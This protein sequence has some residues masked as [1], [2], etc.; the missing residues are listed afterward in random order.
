MRRIV[1]L[2]G[3]GVLVVGVAAAAVSGLRAGTPDSPLP[4]AFARSV[5]RIEARG[6]PGGA[7]QGSGF[8][9]NAGNRVV[10]SLHVVAGC[11]SIGVNYPV[12][13]GQ[14]RTASAMRV[15]KRHD[16]AMLQ[17]TNPPSVPVLPV[18]TAVPGS[19]A[20][21]VAWGYPIKIRG[22]LDTE[23]RRRD[24]V[25]RL[26]DLLNEALRDEI[27]KVG[28]PALD[29]EIIL[30]DRAHLLPGQSGGPLMDSNG[31]VAAIADGGLER[32]ASEINWAIP[33]TRLN[34][35]AASSEAIPTSGV[36]A[37]LFAAEVVE[38][39]SFPEFVVVADPELNAPA[40]SRALGAAITCGSG[41]LVQVKTRT[42]AELQQFTDDPLGLQ[43]IM[44]AAGVLLQPTDEF[45][46][47]QHVPSGATAVLPAG[48]RLSS[49]PLCSGSL[50]Q[51]RIRLLLQVRP[52]STPMA[53]QQESVGYETDLMSALGAGNWQP[54]PAWSM[55]APLNRFDGLV[56]R[57]KA[58][59]QHVPTQFGWVPSKYLFESLTSRGNTFLGVASVRMDMS[60]QKLQLQNA[61]AMNASLPG[62]AELLA[63]LR[64][65]AKAS[66]GVH[67]STFPI[68]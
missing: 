32:G 30:L 65:A 34:E 39:G 57:R 63:E 59:V 27:Q 23:F 28:M 13:G 19:G 11:T 62:C 68:G 25:A 66:I 46:I 38:D 17:V 47:Y 56:A 3:I 31:R 51:G 35:L 24:A 43:Q 58:A 55:L 15:L 36:T 33:A 20:T 16:L 41:E 49:G 42:L 8:V 50:L 1:R 61:C 22:I 29:A 52:A 14:L 18:A 45:D 12:S 7:R 10:T 26:Q 6:C 5:V 60:P 4:P 40:A 37:L 44:N 64:T 67:L 53:V 48:I 21:L 2:A 9:W 54:D